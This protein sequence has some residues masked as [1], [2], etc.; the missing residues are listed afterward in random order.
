MRGLTDKNSRLYQRMI[1]CRM[2]TDPGLE[3]LLELNGNIHSAGTRFLGR[4][5]CVAY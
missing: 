5:S 2:Q 3:T 1:Y 4:N